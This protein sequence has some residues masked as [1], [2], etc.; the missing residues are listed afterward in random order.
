MNHKIELK[1]YE[2]GLIENNDKRVIIRP[3]AG[4]FAKIAKGDLIECNGHKLLVLGVRE[5]PRLE[6]LF[7]VESLDWIAM[8]VKDA[9]EGIKKFKEDYSEV[10]DKDSKFLAIEFSMQGAESYG[11]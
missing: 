1:T 7:H 8:K 11:V 6:D 3:K 10:I 9:V 5:Y 4:S 2:S